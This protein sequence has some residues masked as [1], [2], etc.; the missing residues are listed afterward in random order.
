MIHIGLS[1]KCQRLRGSVFAC[2]RTSHCA[3]SQLTFGNNRVRRLAQR[4]SE[5]QSSN[6]LDVIMSNKRPV[7][8]TSPRPNFQ[9]TFLISSKKS[10]A[11]YLPFED[12]RAGDL[13]EVFIPHG[14]PGIKVSWGVLE[15]PLSLLD[16]R[17]SDLDLRLHQLWMELGEHRHQ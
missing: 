13:V 14:S 9:F 17:S 6:C 8:I 2:H 5:P 10:G 3:R 1:R 12:T 7:Y 16:S 11:S 4:P 15:G